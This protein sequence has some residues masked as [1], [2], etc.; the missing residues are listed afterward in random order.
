SGDMTKRDVYDLTFA[1]DLMGVT[2]FRLEALPDDSLPTRGPGRVYYEGPPGDFFLSELTLR[3]DGTMIRFAKASH[4][5]AS[6]GSS[7]A[8]AI[9]GNTDTGWSINGGQGKRHTA[10]FSVAVP[11]SETK[12]VS[13]QLLF[14]KYYAAG[15]GHFRI[16]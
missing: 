12:K 3:A 13:L 4:S 6:S 11:L 7:A 2:A 10:V 8:A 1:E 5:F 9:D 15:L 14:E 16:S